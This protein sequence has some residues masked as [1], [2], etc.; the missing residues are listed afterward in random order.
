MLSVAKSPLCW[1]LCSVSLCWVSFCWMSKRTGLYWF[2]MGYLTLRVFNSISG[3]FEVLREGPLQPLSITLDCQGRVVGGLLGS[4]HE[5]ARNW[6]G[7]VVG[8][9]GVPNPELDESLGWQGDEVIGGKD[10][11]RALVGRHLVEVLKGWK[12]K[13]RLTMDVFEFSLNI[14]GTA[15]DFKKSYQNPLFCLWG[16]SK[17]KYYR[18]KF[19]EYQHRGGIHST[20]YDHLTIIVKG[21]APELPMADVKVVIPLVIRHPYA[22]KWT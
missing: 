1:M 12:N 20:S 14:E 3:T 6:Y 10:L 16:Y 5:Q 4:P 17:W 9:S 2:F 18:K 11:I 19:C 15:A 7:V 13:K 21:R 22:Q 8:R